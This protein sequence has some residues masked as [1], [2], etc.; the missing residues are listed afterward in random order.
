MRRDEAGSY[1]RF[2]DEVTNSNV[3][4]LWWLSISTILISYGVFF[5]NYFWVNRPA[6]TPVGFSDII[7][8]PVMIALLWL[9]RRTPAPT[10][11][12]RALVP[13]YVVL[14]LVVMDGYF[15][16]SLPLVGHNS[17]YVLGVMATAVLILL[18]PALFLSLIFANHA[19]YCLLILT[20]GRN[21]DFIVSAL[22]DASSAVL[23]GSLASYF[24]YTARWSNFRKE[25]L[26]AQRNRELAASNREL[27]ERAKEMDELMAIAAHDLRSP[28]EGQQH[29]L[30]LTRD[31]PAWRPGQLAEV[32]D[33]AVQSCRSMLAL[34][35]R[36]LDAHQ[37]EH[38]GQNLPLERADLRPL[39]RDAV[40]RATPAATAKDIRLETDLPDTPALAPVQ[41]APLSEVLDNLLTNA[42]KFSPS[43]STISIVLATAE[44]LSHLEI[45]DEGPGIPEDERPLLFRKFHRGAN[46]PTAGESTSG[47]GLFIVKKLI[48]SMHG[49]VE[50]IPRQPKGSIFRLRFAP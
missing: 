21:L 36:L 39:I 37:A 27:Q 44:N 5:F 45:R 1:R 41:S 22:V 20:S 50:Y 40:A 9:A 25:R 26:I 15:F 23:I 38:L 13:F 6:M 16:S 3:N 7:L 35:G 33:I 43:A 48:E 19:V 4:R 8:S 28:L 11:W 49:S 2:V 42:L 30:I 14:M 32:L 18:P 29:L 12:K 34:V 17:S 31:R 10:P 47:M 24:L 46:R